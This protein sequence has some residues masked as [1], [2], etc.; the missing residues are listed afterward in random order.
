MAQKAILGVWTHGQT[1]LTVPPFVVNRRLEGQS[2]LAVPRLAVNLNF[3]YA[4]SFEMKTRPEVV[5]P[6]MRRWESLPA[7]DFP[8][9][10]AGS[11]GPKASADLMKAGERAWRSI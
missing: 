2:S 5:D 6:I 11:A 8:N 10:E 4:K 1:S 9:Y 3:D 7:K